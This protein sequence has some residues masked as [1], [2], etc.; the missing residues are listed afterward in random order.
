MELHIYKRMGASRK[1][2]ANTGAAMT[3]VGGDSPALINPTVVGVGAEKNSLN[4]RIKLIPSCQCTW[5]YAA[6]C[7]WL[8]YASASCWNLDRARML[9]CLARSPFR[10]YNCKAHEFSG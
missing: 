6:A 5:G 7:L 4:K 2:G 10:L 1:P 3:P 9:F 8:A